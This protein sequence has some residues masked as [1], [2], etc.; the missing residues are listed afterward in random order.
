MRLVTG[1]CLLFDR[2][3]EPTLEFRHFRGA[4]FTFPAGSLCFA[5]E[6]EARID[7]D[8]AQRLGGTRDGTLRLR[9]MGMGLWFE[10][11]LDR[12]HWIVAAFPRLRGCSVGLRHMLHV[13]EGPGRQVLAAEVLEV[14]LALKRDPGCADTKKYLSLSP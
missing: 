10:L 12:R 4:P 8:P 3:C 14:T 5:A 7:H 9:E 2:P 13:P 1:Y 11:A 6:V